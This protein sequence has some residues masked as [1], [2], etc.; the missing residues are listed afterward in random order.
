MTWILIINCKIQKVRAEWLT[1]DGKF[2]LV[3]CALKHMVEDSS[4]LS[5]LL[6]PLNPMSQILPR[7]PQYS[8]GNIEP[9]PIC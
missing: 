2:F 4:H 7:F 8:E 1:F 5:V 9:P 6:M 3:G